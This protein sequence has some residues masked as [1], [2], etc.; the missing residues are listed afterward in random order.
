MDGKSPS[1]V[2]GTT[3]GKVF[4][5]SP[6]ER[7]LQLE[8]G[9]LPNTRLLNFNRAITSLTAGSL[10]DEKKKPETLFVG[11]ASG[12]L[13]YDINRNSD[14]FSRDVQDG[15]NAL[16]IGKTSN[17]NAPS[18]LFAGG[19]C[20]II[21]FD[22]EGNEAFW[23]VTGDNV[24]SLE[25]FDVDSD[26]LDELVVGSD[27]FE[28]RTYRNEDVIA[29]V[30]EVDRIMLLHRTNNNNFAFGLAN[31]TVGVYTGPSKRAWRTKSKH[32]VTA[33]GSYDING[34]GVKE[35]VTGWSDGTFDVRREDNGE[36]IYKDELSDQMA[37]ASVESV[38][39]IVTTDYRMD[40]KDSLMICMS[41][42]EIKGFHPADAEISATLAQVSLGTQNDNQADE[43]QKLIDEL[44]KEKVRLM[45]ELRLLEKA[46]NSAKPG[47]EPIAGTL[48]HGTKLAY[49]LEPILSAGALVL[50][51]ESTT[52]IQ[53]VNVVVTESE[54]AMFVGHEAICVSPTPA[55]RNASVSLMPAKNIPCK[56]N[57]QSHLTPRGYD[58]HLH[59]FE[60]TLDVPRFSRFCSIPE[61]PNVYPIPQSKV[62][63]YINEN[64]TSMYDWLKS[65]FLLSASSKGVKI[66]ANNDK[67]K[68]NFVAVCPVKLEPTLPQTDIDFDEAEMREELENRNKTPQVLY[69]FASLTSDESRSKGNMK[70]QIACESM[71][72]AGELIQDMVK[73]FDISELESDADFPTELSA[74]ETVLGQVSELNKDRMKLTANMAEESATVKR[75]IIRAEDSRCMLDMETMRK[76]YTELYGLNNSLIANYNV[77][78]KSHEQLL[79]SLKEV[80]FMIQKAAN[81]RYGTAKSRVIS[82]CRKAVKEN[83]LSVLF[84]I[85]RRG[86]EHHA[87]ATNVSPKRK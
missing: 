63:F 6:H 65:C 44:M 84:K 21:G 81:L 35:V 68:A 41:S 17:Y 77:R 69:I 83:N 36:V 24:S 32:R 86:R 71:D 48:P 54:G 4:V 49:F 2:C 60:E 1:L 82:E 78:A 85:V 67:L 50:Q 47:G 73:F 42:G 3:G 26:G 12:L 76:A 61:D 29:E 53:I 9:Q 70:V 62:V 13:A 15:V 58:V 52:E 31:G 55:K 43:D 66:T 64:I 16:K 25:V 11:S 5:H 23:T 87:N 10:S 20:S 27:D 79:A 80:N 19:N 46:A 18:L 57:I 38:A 30:S 37:I 7:L 34:D 40:G 14:V 22:K 75:L 56:I 39:G 33:L 72:L 8:D 51:I 45:K 59:V 28:I 74:F